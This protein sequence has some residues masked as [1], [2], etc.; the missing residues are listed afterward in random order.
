MKLSKLILDKKAIKNYGIKDAY[1]IHKVVY[2]L[3]PKSQENI[4]NKRK[5]LFREKAGDRYGKH[6]LLLSAVKPKT[7]EFGTIQVKEIPQKFFER[8]IYKFSVRMNPVKRLSSNGYCE[9]IT[10]F[11]AIRS[12]FLTKCGTYGFSV[13]PET[14][15]ITG[16]GVQQFNKG[17][18]RI[19]HN[20]AD[21]TGVLKVEERDR[22]LHSV[23]N[24]LGRGKS[25]GFGLLE[26]IPIQ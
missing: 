23:E 3:F 12:W 10:D 25:F 7:P 13:I 16:K 21:L 20:Y 5:F 8:E 1:G 4:E 24:G 22:F 15:E 19:V 26:L 6:I 18:H 9:A 11:E 2:S 14:F 17:K